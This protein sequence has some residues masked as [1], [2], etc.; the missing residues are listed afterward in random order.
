[1]LDVFLVFTAMAAGSG[2]AIS[3]GSVVI[4]ASA[5][6]ALVAEDQTPSGKFTTATEVKPIIAMTQSSW[7]AVREWDGQDLVYVTHLWSWR[8]GLAQMEV[9]V[10]GAASEVWPLPPCHEDTGQPNAIIDTDGLPYRSFAL[11]SIETLDVKVT[12]DDLTTQEASFERKAVL[13]P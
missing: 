4:A 1:M 13:M 2:G 10:N 8:C 9:S 11:K 5:E 12:F 7:V 6:A 3:E